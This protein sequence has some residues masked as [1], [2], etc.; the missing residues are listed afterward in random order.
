ML[1]HAHGVW[2]AS[3]NLHRQGSR[4]NKNI[5]YVNFCSADEARHRIKYWCIKGFEIR[6][7]PEARTQHMFDEDLKD[8]RL[9][10]LDSIPPEETL[11][12]LGLTLPL[13]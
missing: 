8:V 9:F 4:C 1:C 7:E 11:E 13:P 5:T 12:Q 6:D 10:D 3:C 2:S